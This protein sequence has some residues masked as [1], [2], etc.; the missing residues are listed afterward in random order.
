LPP[1]LEG[2]PDEEILRYI[3][4][5]LEEDGRVDLEELTIKCHR[6]VIHIDGF[7][8]SEAEHQVLLEILLDGIGIATLT[9]HV[10]ID[11][12]LW[13]TDERTHGRRDPDEEEETDE[14]LPDDDETSDAY[15]SRTSGAPLEPP[16]EFV[17]EETNRSRKRRP[18]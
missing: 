3:L 15:V 1:D 16:D 6:G 10:T 18:R 7:L 12:L 4:N 17:P 14:A 5:E 9:D 8:P 11:P 2:L 13:E